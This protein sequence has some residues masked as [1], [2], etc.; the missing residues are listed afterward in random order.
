MEQKVW[1]PTFPKDRIAQAQ[2]VIEQVAPPPASE[3]ADESQKQDKNLLCPHC[4]NPV[5]GEPIE[6]EI[7]YQ[8]TEYDNPRLRAEVEARCGP[9][10]TTFLDITG[11]L[12]QRVPAFPGNLELIFRTQ[13]PEESGRISR[14]SR[15][16][17]LPQLYNVF[18]GQLLNLAASLMYAGGSWV[19]AKPIEL[20]D[21]I[22]P[23]DGGIVWR[24]EVFE[25]NIK[26]VKT[27]I[28]TP[29]IVRIIPQL[30]WFMN[31]CDKFFSIDS[32]KK[33]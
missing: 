10:D 1:T 31:R 8:G 5:Y 7:R 33:S 16:S 28:S 11:R 6:M 25:A 29:L 2:E 19:G 17:E 20:P 18:E 26:I 12:I 4:G 9:I 24:Q 13:C 15:D 23:K 21:P 30:V 32:L 22:E 3:S 27:R 14:M